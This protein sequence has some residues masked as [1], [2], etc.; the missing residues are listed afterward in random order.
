MLKGTVDGRGGRGEV[1]VVVK[2][3]FGGPA[4]QKGTRDG[5]ETA[6]RWGI[7]KLHG[8]HPD[9]LICSTIRSAPNLACHSCA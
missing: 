4:R 7:V 6:D 3:R 8:C 2:G 1:V 5:A 9:S